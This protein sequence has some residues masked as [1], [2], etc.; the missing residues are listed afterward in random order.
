MTK[1]EQKDALPCFNF[2]VYLA[3]LADYL[4]VAFIFFRTNIATMMQTMPESIEVKHPRCSI[5][6]VH[7]AVERCHVNDR[8]VSKRRESGVFSRSGA[9]SNGDE[10]DGGEGGI[11]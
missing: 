6:V 11:S 4:G 3:F 8:K 7:P 1:P 5:F 9:T 2:S 10:N